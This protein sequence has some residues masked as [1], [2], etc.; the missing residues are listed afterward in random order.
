M[1]LISKLLIAV[2]AGII[3]SYATL[4]DSIIE[5]IIEQEGSKIL[6]AKLEISEAEFHLFPPSLT[7]HGFAATNPHDPLRNII[8]SSKITAQANS[9]ALFDA[10]RT[11]KIVVESASIHDLRFQQNRKTSGAIDGVTLPAPSSANISLSTATPDTSS[12]IE[13]ARQF[14]QN[15]LDALNKQVADINTQWQQKNELIVRNNKL[16]TFKKRW[17]E[18]Q[19]AGTAEKLAGL[20]QLKKD[21]SAE[22]TDTTKIREDL[23]I[24]IAVTGELEKQ[25]NQ[26]INSSP[27]TWTTQNI[28]SPETTSEAVNILTDKL[29]ADKLKNS[30]NELL[31][32]Y[33]STPKSTPTWPV[34]IRNMNFE[35][36]I[37]LGVN[38]FPIE[39]N[40][41]NL[42]NSHS[43]WQ[44]PTIITAK[45]S[46]NADG[47]FSLSGSFDH[48]NPQQVNDR[49]EISLTNVSITALSL[50]RAKDMRV[51]LGQAEASV[52]G[53]FSLNQNQ[54]LLNI[55]NQ[56]KNAKITLE[57]NVNGSSNGPSSSNAL[58]TQLSESLR[59]IDRFDL[60]ISASGNADNITINTS[61]SIDQLLQSAAN[62]FMTASQEAIRPQLQAALQ[63]TLDESLDKLENT[64]QQLQTIGNN[65]ANYQQ[66][67]RSLISM[68]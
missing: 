10:F 15:K 50:S 36:Q 67:L 20:R 17:A 53:K 5:Q 1:K 11:K 43:Y 3:I 66:A 35:G 68:L 45:Q 2:L 34:L 47:K 18:L 59:T 54:L 63:N 61:S 14:L 12:L 60:Q 48:R 28:Q 56:F 49:A 38:A 6:K 13:N 37:E 64:Q 25:A 57:T 21:V 9:T 7:L 26:L 19:N 4:I 41:Q 23:Q 58:A 29:L 32:I 44:L 33:Q 42:N 8:S 52:T 30:L 27:D 24:D 16:D 51:V 55:D 62:Q 65:L 39:G 46:A 22:L 31:A 40:I